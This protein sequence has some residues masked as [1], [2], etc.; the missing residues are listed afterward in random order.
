MQSW[1]N[2]ADAVADA[3]EILIIAGSSVDDKLG[4]EKTRDKAS[5]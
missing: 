1:H 4:K 5:S 2:N 3:D